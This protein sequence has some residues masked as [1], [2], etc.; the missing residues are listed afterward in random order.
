M[1]IGD[2][3][4]YQGMPATYFPAH[5]AIQKGGTGLNEGYFLFYNGDGTTDKYIYTLDE[6]CG[7]IMLVKSTGQLYRTY[8][9]SVSSNGLQLSIWNNNRYYCKGGAGTCQ[10][11]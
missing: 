5:L 8:G 9:F 4:E 1:L 10:P 6:E 7:S 11:L 2:W 3:Y